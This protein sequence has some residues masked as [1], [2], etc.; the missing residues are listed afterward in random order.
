MAC[1]VIVIL[2]GAYIAYEKSA[3]RGSVVLDHQINRMLETHN[4]KKMKNISADKVTFSFLEKL[5]TDIRCKDSSGVQANDGKTAYFVT[6]LKGQT[7][8]VEMEVKH[9]F[10]TDQWSLSTMTL[11]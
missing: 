1:T 9:G 4:I 7:F 6:A 3:I 8:G 10:F 2:A 11:Q 5:P